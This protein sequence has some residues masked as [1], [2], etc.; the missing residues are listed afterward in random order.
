MARECIDLFGGE[1]LVGDAGERE[2]PFMAALLLPIIEPAQV[3]V[4]DDNED[5]LHLFRRYLSGTRYQFIGLREPHE[6]IQAAGDLVPAAIVLDVMLPGVDGWELLGRLR[7]HPATRELPIV[8]CTVMP[9]EQLA[10]ALGAAAY[11]RKPVSR[12]AFLSALDQQ[13]SSRS[14]VSG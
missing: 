9:Q 10:L 5:T 8:V 7:E 6:V 2:P 11:L 13:V 1:L 3:L 12:E 14:T 4:V